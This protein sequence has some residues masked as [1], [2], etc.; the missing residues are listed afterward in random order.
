[1]KITEDDRKFAAGQSIAEDWALQQ[2]MEAKSKEFVE[3]GAK[4][5]AKAR[6]IRRVQR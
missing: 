1:M 5:F 2:G 6:I 3:R 4:I